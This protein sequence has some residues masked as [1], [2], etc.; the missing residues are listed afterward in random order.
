[1]SGLTRHGRLK[2][3]L[4]DIDGN[5]S[6]NIGVFLRDGYGLQL[7]S[8]E[9]DVDTQ[10]LDV[11]L[12][13]FDTSISNEDGY[14]Y[15]D[16]VDDLLNDDGYVEVFV[17]NPTT[18][19]IDAEYAEDSPHSSGDIGSFS[20]AVRNDSETSLVDTDGDYAPFQVNDVGRLK[21]DVD[22][23]DNIPVNNDG[24][25]HVDVG[26]IEVAT[27]FE[28]EIIDCPLPDGYTGSQSFIADSHRRLWVNNSSAV[29]G[30][31]QT[32]TVNTTA[33]TLLSSELT[34]RT[35]ILIQNMGDEGVYLGFD[36][37]VTADNTSTGG[38]YLDCGDVLTL[39]ISECLSLYGITETGTADVKVLE[40]A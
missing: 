27:T 8:T 16:L 4:T 35:R 6:D 23:S 19:N 34:G 25:L 21:V 18:V 20:L 9:V 1:M 28:T 17:T 5:C 12:H 13:G 3:N 24:Y 33:S 30:S 37:T 29:A 38:F 22:W 31:A 10:A 14:L 26:E 15:V 2:F 40:T 39:E 36:G 11:F 32:V 7:T